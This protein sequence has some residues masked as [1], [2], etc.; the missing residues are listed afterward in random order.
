VCLG[1]DKLNVLPNC[2]RVRSCLRRDFLTLPNRKASGERLREHQNPDEK[3]A[4]SNQ[5]RVSSFSGT[6]SSCHR[7]RV[8]GPSGSDRRNPSRAAF[9]TKTGQQHQPGT[10]D[11]SSS[12][13]DS[14]VKQRSRE[15][16][17]PFHYRHVPSGSEFTRQ[18]L[19]QDREASVAAQCVPRK[20]V[21]GPLTDTLV[22]PKHIHLSNKVN[23][24]RI[25][26]VVL[27]MLKV[28]NPLIQI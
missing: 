4:L 15:G 24:A 12:A 1:V 10:W 20:R 5:A 2:G 11:T 26:Y 8:E 19:Q 13:C 27:F 14:R 18:P 23:C 21:S 17:T 28:C 25:P 16:P 7:L 3:P 6:G 9:G 22:E